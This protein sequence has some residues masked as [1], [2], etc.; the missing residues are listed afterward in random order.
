MGFGGQTNV[1]NCTTGVKMTKKIISRRDFLKTSGIILGG[2]A[3]IGSGLLI[4]E[5]NK[6]ENI[7]PKFEF[8]EKKME[9]RI[10][11]T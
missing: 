1:Q 2:A 5:M 6:P 3:L 11:V 8:G 9:N 10:L 4:P 7:L